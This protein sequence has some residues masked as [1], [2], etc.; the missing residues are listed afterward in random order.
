M[1]TNED[2]AAIKYVEPSYESYVETLLLA[3]R[4]LTVSCSVG[5]LDELARDWELERRVIN[6]ALEGT[7]N[8]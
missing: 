5:D 6:I 3:G 7:I 2:K 1:S 8:K 4:V